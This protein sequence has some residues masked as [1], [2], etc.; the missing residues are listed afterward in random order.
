M[1]FTAAIAPTWPWVG[2]ACHA[3][4]PMA[5]IERVHSGTHYL[6]GVVDGTVIGLAAATLV[7]TTPRFLLHCRG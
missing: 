6:S 1:A 7:R 4:T 5:G 3:L 2:A